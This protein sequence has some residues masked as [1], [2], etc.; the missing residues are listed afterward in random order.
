MKPI[1]CISTIALA[2]ALSSPVSAE[3]HVIAHR[4]YWDAPGA[5]QN[6]IR[7]IVKADSIGCYGSEFDVWITADSVL[8][9]NHDSTIHGVVIASSKADEVLAQKL[10]NGEN[11]PTLEQ[12]L[13]TAVPM[14]TRLIFELKEHSDR[15]QEHLAVMRCIEMIHAKGLDDRTEYITFSYPAM[16]DFIKYAPAGTPV[17]YLRGDKTPQELKDA[18]AA[19]P[20]YHFSV[21]QAHPEWIQ[22]CHDLGMKV[23]AWTVDDPA[24]MQWC[25]DHGVDF[26]TTNAPEPLQQLLAK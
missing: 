11:L 1:A 22:E 21:F 18:G 8:V 13:D 10:P 17:Y 6:S 9:V 14:S 12:Y 5:S 15:Q 2:I 16:L 20:D 26:I 4:G 24:I 7:S 23:N 19:G 3:T 25:I